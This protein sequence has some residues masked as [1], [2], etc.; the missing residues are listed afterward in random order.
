MVTKPREKSNLICLWCGKPTCGDRKIDGVE[1][2]FP[3]AI[4]GTKTLPAGSVCMKCNHELGNLDRFLKKEHP[5]MMD[6]FQVDPRIKGRKREGMDKK[7]KEKERIF[8]EG[9]GEAKHTKISRKNHPNVEFINAIFI[10]TSETFLRALHKCI[11]NVL[12]DKYGSI[13]TRKKYRDLL[14]FVKDGGDVRPWS[15]AISFP[16]PFKRPLINEPKCFFLSVNGENK[17]I[18]GFIHTSGIWIVG[19]HPFLLN[20]EVIETVSELVTKEIT[21]IKEPATQKP[22]TDFFGFD[23][24]LS[25]DR[26]SIGKLRFFWAVE[27]MKGKPS[28][29]FLHLLIKCKLCGQTNST[30]I[31]LPREIIYKGNVNN[32]ISYNKNTWNCYTLEDLERLGFEVEKW[33]K[34]NL[35]SYM[36]Q[37]ISIPI[38][39]DVRKL[40]IHNCKTTCIN[41]GDIISYGASDCF[42]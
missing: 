41:C 24:S 40:E 32:V 21:H 29:G 31:N 14:K 7:R 9:E 16:T 34:K 3:K 27:E 33:D 4:G 36:T 15:Y 28:D 11:A 6:A 19:S 1:H 35:E 42:I 13:T 17:N 12:C 37:G 2:I 39:N 26:V 23:W 18:I 25:K 5:A 20:P 22:M 38:E 10:V 30:G 8:I